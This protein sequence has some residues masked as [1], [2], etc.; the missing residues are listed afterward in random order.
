MIINLK[1]YEI[2]A[3][4]K[5]YVVAQGINLSQKSIN[6]SFTAGRKES[7]ITAEVT[8]DD[9]MIPGY[10]D[11]VSDT[12]L[13]TVIQLQSAAV[14]ETKEVTNET[15]VEAEANDDNGNPPEP[16]KSLFGG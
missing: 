12:P 7:G 10:T 5:A 9:V 13:A 14:E 11:A 3:A 6:I 16:T 1:Q 4:L 15:V 8:I 2:E